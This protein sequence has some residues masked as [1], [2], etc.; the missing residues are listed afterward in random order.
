M[1]RKFTILISSVGRRAQLVEC[2]R[3]AASELH[4]ALTIVG[5][6][7]APQLSPASHLVDRC[8][9][10]PRCSD[11][12]FLTGTVAICQRD[13]IDLVI[14]TIDPELPI[15]AAHAGEFESIGAKVLIS[16]P[17]TIDIAFD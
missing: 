5:T 11:S 17:R 10:V 13:K 7:A 6:D 3:R 8:F 2:F 15:F 1:K 16:D 4:L 9:K 12:D 14:P